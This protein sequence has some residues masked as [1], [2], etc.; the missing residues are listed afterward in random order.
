MS[1]MYRHIVLALALLVLPMASVGAAQ[2]SERCFPE[3][4]FCIAG[5]IREFWERNGGLPVFG[6]PKGPQQE[7]IIEGRPIQAQQFERNRLELHPEN[8]PPYDVL[9]GRL[10]ADRLAQQGRDPFTFPRSEPQPGCRFFPETQHNVCG[11]ILAAWRASGLEFD[12]Q[13]G[14]SEPESLALF[15]LPLSDLQTEEVEGRPYQVQWFER[16][17]FELHP[18]NQPPYHVLLGLLG[19]EILAGA[20]PPAPPAPPAPLP[21]PPPSFNGCREDPRAPD[22]PNYPVQIADIN[23]GAE[24]VTLRNISPDPV[25]L[26]GWR[27]CSI[28]GN[29]EHPIGGVLAPGESRTF[30][31]PEGNIWNNSEPDDGALYNPQ[32]QLVSYKFD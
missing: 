2:P 17:R 26:S 22:A 8:Q 4:G 29:Q 9:L 20:P 13:P 11:E 27:M 12:G 1:G 30:P 7:M 25:D 10:G 5:R 6:F 28:R 15:G 19:N 18:E 24:T 23:D 3:T 16:A 32:G 21:L 31:G 14:V